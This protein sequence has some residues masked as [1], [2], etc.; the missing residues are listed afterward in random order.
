VVGHGVQG[1]SSISGPDG[2]H[3]LTHRGGTVSWMDAGGLTDKAGGSLTASTTTTMVG[4]IDYSCTMV[5][6]RKTLL[7]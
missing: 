1:A 4:K 6:R 7:Y 3:S 2:E 5:L